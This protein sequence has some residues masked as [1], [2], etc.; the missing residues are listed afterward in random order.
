MHPLPRLQ[1][2]V[3]GLQAA[4]HEEEVRCRARH[5]LLRRIRRHGFRRRL[6]L[7]HQP[8]VMTRQH[9][10]QVACRPRLHPALADLTQ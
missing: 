10:R 3:A 8:G 2:N 5:P 1:Y 7:R 4:G 6:R 9:C